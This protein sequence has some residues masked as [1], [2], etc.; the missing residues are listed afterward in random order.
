M[1]AGRRKSAGAVPA[2]PGD[3]DRAPGARPRRR[4]GSAGR[5]P[6]AGYGRPTGLHE[7]RP[8][9]RRRGARLRVPRAAPH[10]RPAPP[11]PPGGAIRRGLPGRPDRPPGK[12]RTVR[13]RGRRARRDGSF[14]K[15][16]SR[17]VG[18]SPNSVAA[19]DLGGDHW[20]RRDCDSVR[21]TSPQCP[22]CM[23]GP[24]VTVKSVTRAD[25]M[26]LTG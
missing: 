1:G 2:V 7:D 26:C 4:P 9:H 23:A 15:A 18:R 21:Q 20:V 16:T 11:P 13:R 12:E 14:G 22:G 19:A 8:G 25:R 6:V 5:R 24:T 17:K 3:H 10:T